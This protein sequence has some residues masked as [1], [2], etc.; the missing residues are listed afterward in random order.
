MATEYK[1]KEVPYFSKREGDSLLFNLDGYLEYYVPEDYF[2]G[3]SGIMEGSYVRL[4]GSF[5]YRIF[6]ENDK[7]GNLM[8]FNCPTMFLCRPGETKKKVKL[9]LDDHLD[10]AE[11]RVLIFRKGDQLI[12]RI[13]TEQE[14]DNMSEL[15]R[16]HLKTGKVPN[17]I[18]YDQ[19]YLFPY[20]CM[21]LNGGKYADNNIH[22]QEFM[23]VPEGAKDFR[24]AI[25][26]GAEIYKALEKILKANGY[27]ILVA[28]AGGFAPNLKNENDAFKYII[29]AIKMA[30]YEV[31]KEVALALDIA[32]TEMYEAAKKEGKEGYLFWKTG[33]LKSPQEMIEYIETLT[34]KYPIIS[35]EDGLAEEDWENWKILTDEIGSDIMLVGDDLFVTNRDRLIRGIKEDVANTILI[36]PNQ[37]GT[38]TETLDCIETAKQNGYDVI[39][40]HRSGETEDTFIADLAVAVNAGYIK[41]GAPCR[42]DRIIKYNRLISIE[43]ELK[44]EF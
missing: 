25:R 20:E 26:M 32:S 4:L 40:S 36:K 6:D 31:G 19:L 9:K 27:T 1:Y 2:I 14:M 35:I 18:P 34:D 17:T 37:I 42:T 7:P 8:T 11:Y 28:D 12:T 33:E 29:E 43:N 16:L 24:Q 13:H 39:I 3:K 23:I 21:S 22:I 38:V 30:G 10:E 44:E 15:F 41:S 5:N